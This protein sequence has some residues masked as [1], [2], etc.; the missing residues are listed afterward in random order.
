MLVI[1]SSCALHFADCL[2]HT[3][4]IPARPPACELSCANIALTMTQRT[5]LATQPPARPQP[6]LNR[7]HRSLSCIH[8]GLPDAQILRVQTHLSKNVPVPQIGKKINFPFAWKKY[9]PMLQHTPPHLQK[10]PRVDRLACA[11]APAATSFHLQFRTS[12]TSDHSP[13]PS[14]RQPALAPPFPS[15]QTA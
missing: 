9:G 13:A 12:P 14:S 8:R 1:I 15:P 10:P 5:L 7:S 11:G 2:G 4:P 3:T 6:A